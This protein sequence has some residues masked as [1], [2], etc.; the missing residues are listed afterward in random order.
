[1][2]A[3]TAAVVLLLVGTEAFFTWLS[4]LN[5]RYG[6]EEL[7]ER[8]EWVRDRL[9]VD[10]PLELAE[11]QRAK[12]GL[13]SLG[14][15]VL[16]GFVLLVLLSGLFA[17]TVAALQ[18]T[19][20]PL[21]A[22]GVVFFAGV[23]AVLY[24]VSLPFDVVETFVVEEIY[25]FNEQSVALFLRDSAL[26]LLISGVL[27]SVLGTALL[28]VVL[29]IPQWWALAGAGLFFAFGLLMQ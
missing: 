3:R 4:A 15:W 9:D 14:S 28:A 1:M 21:L 23:A 10:D 29:T 11:Y 12:V 27:A 7:A 18:R 16:L 17:D 6:G 19:G 20:W 5:L 8:A 13:D 25:D 22:Q 2:F 24:L 26:K